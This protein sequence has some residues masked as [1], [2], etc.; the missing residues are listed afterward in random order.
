MAAMQGQWADRRAFVP[1]LS[2]YGAVLKGYALPDYYSDAER[3]VEGQA[4]VLTAVEPDVLFAPFALPLLGQAFGGQVEWLTDQAPN[5]HTPPLSSIAEVGQ[6]K[7][8]DCSTNAVLQYQLRCI[9][10]MRKRFGQTVPVV[11]IT[12]SPVDLPIMLMGL[13]NW[14]EVFLFDAAGFDRMMKLAVPFFL[15]WVQHLFDAGA[16][17]VVL[18]AAFVS[19]AV[20]TRGQ[21]VKRA[22]PVYQSVFSRVSGPLLLHGGGAPIGKFLGEYRVLPKQVAG[23]VLDERDDLAQARQDAGPAQVLLSGPDG[24]HMG[25]MTAD[26]VVQCCL[27]KL[28]NRRGDPRFILSTSGADVAPQTPLN[29]LLLMRKCVEDCV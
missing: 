5:L 25:H 4:A 7:V 17:C 23:Y 19:S 20:V 28:E 1:L 14:M 2:L 21:A 3:Y 27:D 13:E 8:P 29:H 11:A 18:P 24:E 10:A 6:L 9:A 16:A 26:E 12:L 15:T 22:L